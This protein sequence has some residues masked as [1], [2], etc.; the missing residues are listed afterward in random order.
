MAA[1]MVTCPMCNKQ[2]DRNSEPYIK[3]GQRY[4]HEQCYN[5][6][7]LNKEWKKRIHAFCR[8]KY[9]EQYVKVRIDKQLKELLEDGT[10]TLPG[11][12]QALVWHYNV[13]NGDVSKSYG[14]IRIVDYIYNEAQLYYKQK[15]EAAQR[16][17]K[18]L[19][20]NQ[21]TEK[22]IYYVRPQAIK[23]PK[24]VNLFDLN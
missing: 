16:N 8:E 2:F 19:E 18:M 9:K 7:L 17:A 11:I 3:V 23:K 4:A 21:E 22:E 6:D 10:K 5:D 20:L 24:K 15:Y 12:Y 14:S 1:R 13:N